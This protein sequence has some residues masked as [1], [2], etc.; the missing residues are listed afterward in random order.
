MEI[1]EP[2]KA[3]GTVF[4]KV[5][6]RLSMYLPK[7]GREIAISP[8]M[9]HDPWM[10]S[11]LNNQDLLESSALIDQ[12]QHQVVAHEGEVVT[13][14]SVPKPGA[15]VSW[16]RLEQRIRYDGL[17]LEIRYFCKK[18]KRNRVMRFEE[19]AERAGRVIPTRW[20]MQPNARPDERTI[21][22]VEQIRLD[23]QASD[24]L[25]ESA[26]AAAEQGG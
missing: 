22:E 6:N 26:G 17:P 8:A 9:M 14:E 10:G 19:P 21:I 4:L 18:G 25:F 3:K 11:D 13:I 2:R 5:D 1:L 7:L 16:V 24:D 23:I 15:A 20:V 12:Y